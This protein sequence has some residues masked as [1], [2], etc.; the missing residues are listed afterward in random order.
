VPEAPKM[1][2][3]KLKDLHEK[4]FIN[5]EQFTRLE[6]ILSKKIFSVFY[7]LRTL[8]YLGVLLF[9]TGVGILI[10]LNIGDLGHVLSIIALSVLTLACFYYAFKTSAPYS[11]ARTFPPT[12]YFDY[13]VLLGCLLFISVLGYLQFQY[14]LLDENLG[15]TTLVAAAVF[16]ITA[17]RFDHLGV[18]SLAI[19]AF[20][21]FWGLSVSPQEWYHSD[22]FTT[23]NLHVTAIIFGSGLAGVATGLYQ[24]GMKQHFTFTY[25]NFCSLIFLVG[26]LAGIFI[27]EDAYGIYLLLLYT[28][29]A[30]TVYAGYSQK[31][32]LFL[33]YAFVFGYIGTTY[34]L[35]DVLADEVIIWY[36]YFLGSCGG[37]VFFIIQ[38]KSY[39]KRES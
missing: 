37:F 27:N 7:E 39:F 29:C 1:R 35:L 15:E 38:Y 31:S 23:E 16:F 2:L 21:S 25:F 18:L 34:F 10:Y 17:Y 8:L 11:N 33:L 28:G 24:R 12:P 4:N 3:E 36:L 13:V 6:Q 14:N 20:A 9:T 19:T 26:A 5:D 32:F 30:L 22:F